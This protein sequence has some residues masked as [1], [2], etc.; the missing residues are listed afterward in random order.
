MKG[1]VSTLSILLFFLVIFSLASIISIKGTEFSDIATRNLILDRTY[2]KFISIEYG[3]ERILEEEL[4]LANLSFSIVENKF[5]LVAFNQTLPFFAGDFREDIKRFENFSE[6]KMSEI[7]LI[8]DLDFDKLNECGQLTIIPYNISYGTLDGSVCGFGTGQRDLKIDPRNSWTFVNSYKMIFKVNASLGEAGGSWKSAACKKDGTL[9]W[10]I[11]VV[12][13]D[14]TYGPQ[15]GL[16]KPSANCNFNIE[17]SVG[18]RI[19]QASNEGNSVLTI[20]INPGFSVST[21]VTLNLTDTPGKVRIGLP[22]QSIKVKETLYQIEKND[23]VYIS[24]E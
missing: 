1:F 18:S 22:P 24:G 16:I 12:G 11:T 9:L 5:N 20:T 10:N 21:S 23:T 7:N 14:S 4:N 6:T 2:N 19:L 17:N 13:N 15:T 3:I 8:V